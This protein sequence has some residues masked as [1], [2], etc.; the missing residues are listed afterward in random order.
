VDVGDAQAQLQR[1]RRV[2]D[3]IEAR[4]LAWLGE[5]SAEA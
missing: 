3:E 4:V 1:F 2:R 5:L